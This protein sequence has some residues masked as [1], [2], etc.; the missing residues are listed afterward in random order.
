MNG[1]DGLEHKNTLLWQIGA[2]AITLSI[3][4]GAGM[5]ASAATEPVHVAGLVVDYGDG[6]MTYAWIP[7]SEDEISGVDLLERSGLPVL[8]VGF[9]GIGDAVCKIVKTGCDVS[10]CRLRL[11]QTADHSSPFWQYLRLGP[12]GVWSK[13]PLG[14]SQSKVTDG[15]IDAWVWAGSDS[16]PVLPV[17]SLDSLAKQ[18]GAGSGANTLTSG[19]IRPFFRTTGGPGEGATGAPSSREEYLIASALLFAIAGVGG[20]MVW[21]SHQHR[22]QHSL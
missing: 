13:Q 14:G 19:S 22:G 16:M 15:A 3:L 6:A 20:V 17:L 5:P 18:A 2:L 8:T 9:G 12:D 1:S 11:C 4:L 10:A 7:F 21:R